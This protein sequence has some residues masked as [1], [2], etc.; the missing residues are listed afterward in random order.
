MNQNQ[1]WYCGICDKTSIDKSKTKHNNSN[2]H[3][4][5]EKYDTVVKEYE[6]VKPD[7]DEVNYILNYTITDCRNKYFH[8]FEYR[9]VYDMKFTIL[10]NNEEV[11]LTITLEYM[12][13]KSQLYD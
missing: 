10:E 12:K 3:K 7:F 6:F 9:W 8:S 5:K 4:S 1:F 2:T 13:F 11:N